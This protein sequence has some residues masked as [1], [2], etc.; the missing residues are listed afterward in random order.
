[1]KLSLITPENLT[2]NECSAAR[3]DECL[4]VVEVKVYNGSQAG[5]VTI[6]L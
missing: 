2:Y 5:K 6:F 4:L 3:D 1:M